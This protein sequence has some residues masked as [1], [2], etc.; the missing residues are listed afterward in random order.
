MRK[1]GRADLDALDVKILELYQRDT[2]LPAHGI[3]K[4]VGLSAAAVQRRLKALRAS[5]V[6]TRE[7]AQLDPAA[8]GLGVTCIVNVRL[9]S[10]APPALARFHKLVAASPEVQQCY[11]VTG[12]SDFVL[13]ILVADMPAFEALTHGPLFTDRNIR[14]FTTQVVLSRTKVGLDVCL[15]SARRESADAG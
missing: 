2:Q 6:I 11:Y 7:A 10:D 4:A 3:G 15:D 9:V 1:N 14:K 8:L 5:G 13:I 12:S